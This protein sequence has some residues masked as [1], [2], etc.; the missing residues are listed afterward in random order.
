MIKNDKTNIDEKYKRF[1]KIHDKIKFKAFGKVTIRQRRIPKDKLEVVGKDTAK[2]LLEAQQKRAQSEI[3]DIEKTKRGK[4][5]KVWEIKKKVLGGKKTDV[6]ATAIIN[7]KTG[8]LA[9]SKGE[10]KKVSLQYTK[11][12]LMSNPIEEG[13]AEEIEQK[14]VATR[15]FLKESGGTFE[16]NK[17]IFEKVLANFKGSRKRNY[18][19]IVRADKMF[20]EK[21]YE[22]CQIMIQKDEIPSEF[23]KTTL[24]MIYKGKSKREDLSKN[25]FFHSKSWFPRLVE[26]LVVEGTLK[27]PLV[28]KSSISNSNQIIDLKNCSLLWKMRSWPIRNVELIQKQ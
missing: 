22:L 18:D 13:V 4:V 23:R 1:E 8:N 19:V 20:Q 17:E 21:V 5:R 26:G 3:E 9:L 15:K 6:E 14:K 7:P 16:I 11:E 12:T 27:K 2:E 25:R 28:E 10:I 24:H